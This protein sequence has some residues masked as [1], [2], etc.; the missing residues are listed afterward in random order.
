MVKSV[1]AAALGKGTVAARYKSTESDLRALVA[2][3]RDRAARVKKQYEALADQFAQM[4][5]LTQP[6]KLVTQLKAEEKAQLA[7]AIVSEAKRDPGAAK[8]KEVVALVR[9]E[10]SFEKAK[11]AAA[12]A[13]QKA[14]SAAVRACGGKAA[15][16]VDAQV[17]VAK[18]AA[19]KQVASAQAGLVKATE[20]MQKVELKTESAKAFAAPTAP[21]APA[22]TPFNAKP[23]VVPTAEKPVLAKAEKEAESEVKLALSAP[24]K[25]PPP[26]TPAQVVAALGK[27]GASLKVVAP[28]EQKGRPS[29]L[30]PVVQAA[31]GSGAKGARAAL[32]A[33]AGLAKQDWK[34]G[35]LAMRL[36]LLRAKKHTPNAAGAIRHALVLATSGAQLMYVATARARL[37]Q[38]KRL[39]GA[40]P[41]GVEKAVNAALSRPATYLAGF[42]T[43]VAGPAGA[44]LDIARKAILQLAVTG[45]RVVLA[46]RTLVG[47]ARWRDVQRAMRLYFEG[48]ARAKRGLR[49]AAESLTRA[50]PTKRVASR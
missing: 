18:K 47:R 44:A 45:Q 34:R 48:L 38:Q 17:G 13:I 37:L 30:P 16:C 41:V 21:T 40:V 46:S 5:R 9:A 26:K 2:D 8:Q 11:A 3:A 14:E 4:K 6:Q 10:A 43:R 20:A 35:I 31:S 23:V 15:T 28:K 42:G 49:L 22:T 12:V 36:T 1:F 27:D 39:F 33:M 19:E 32:A 50:T 29:L 25:L 24:A 7:K